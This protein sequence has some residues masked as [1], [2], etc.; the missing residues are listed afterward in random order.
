MDEAQQVR[1]EVYFVDEAHF[2]ADA[3]LQGAARGTI[4]GDLG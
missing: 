2:R 1:A 3:D 4:D